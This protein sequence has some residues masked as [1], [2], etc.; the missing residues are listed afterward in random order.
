[1]WGVTGQQ[2][3]YQIRPDE[4]R[5]DHRGKLVKYETPRG[6]KMALDVPPPARPW[7]MDPHRPLFITEGVRKADA[8]VSRGLCCIA[9]LGVWNWRGTNEQ[10]GTLAL[11]DWEMVALK[12]RRV[13]IVFDSDVM[14]KPAVHQALARLKA[15]LES[16]GAQV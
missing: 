2:M 5:V 14:L 7:L 16:R 9:L 13:Y 11:A 1:G 8:A 10:G 4:P 12:E 3:T 15:F 6:S